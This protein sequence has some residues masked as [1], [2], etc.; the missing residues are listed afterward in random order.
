MGFGIVLLCLLLYLYIPLRM[1]ALPDSDW[2][3]S[4]DL[5][6]LVQYLTARIY[7]YRFLAGG[8]QYVS[9]QVSGLPVLFGKQF[10]AAWVL[11]VPG[12]ISLWRT[13][14]N[15]LVALLLAAGVVT[16][17][18]LAYNIPDKEG[19]LLPAYLALVIVIG[20]GFAS[21][22][23]T[24]FRTVVTVAGLLVILLLPM[25]NYA[26]QD[27][28]RIRGLSDLSSAVLV[29][30]PDKAVLFTDDYSIFQGIRWQQT[31]LGK[32]PD[33]IVV[34]EHHLAFPWYLTQLA[35]RMPVPEQARGLAVSLWNQPSRI[36]GQDFGELAKSRTAEI[37][38]TLVREWLGSA[39]LFWIPRDFADWPQEWRGYRLVLHGLDYQISEADLRPKMDFSLPGPER[40]RTT[41]FKDAES[42]DLCLRFAAVVCR[43][44][45][46]RFSLNDNAGALA[47]FSRSLEYFP[48]YPA[49][50]ENKGIVFSFAGTP[51]SSRFYLE[52]FIRLNPGSPELPKVRQILGG[53]GR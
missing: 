26:R 43:R 32:R 17:A 11:L 33:V 10:L 47:D 4:P 51:D 42:Q 36:A 28:S 8:A 45:I 12:A 19:Y 18:A 39:R 1:R 38:A 53:L 52:R 3:S 35:R 27:R 14:R 34:S 23:A 37:K 13:R 50:L 6:G 48:D 22:L 7:R 2:G 31:G 25:L 29:N 9:G 40:Y 24:R 30:L 46:L 44:G 49:A 41:L 16:A 21:L 20:V 15:L 5:G